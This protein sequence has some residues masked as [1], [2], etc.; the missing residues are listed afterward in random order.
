M[1]PSPQPPAIVGI[2][3]GTNYSMIATMAADGNPVVHEVD[4]HPNR[5]IPSAVCLLPGREGVGEESKRLAAIK[6]PLTYTRFKRTAMASGEEFAGAEGPVTAIDL[7]ARIL[8][9]LLE[10]RALED[11]EIGTAVVTVP[12]EF[13]HAARQATKEAAVQAGLGDVRLVNEPTAAAVYYVW[14]KGGEFTGNLAVFDLGGGTLDVTILRA[15]GWRVEV[16]ATGGLIDLGG[17]DFDDA[18]VDFVRREYETR[19]GGSLEPEDFTVID[20][21]RAKINL[22]K[23]PEERIKVRG[24]VGKLT[25]DITRSQFEELITPVLSRISG[26]IEDVIERSGLTVADIDQLLAVGGSTRI[27]AVRRIAAEH[28]GIE[29]VSFDHVDQVVAKGAVVFA[30]KE[31]EETIRAVLLEDDVEEEIEELEIIE[32]TGKSF[33]TD[34]TDDQG[35]YYHSIIIPVGTEIPCSKTRKYRVRSSE[36]TSLPC[37]VLESSGTDRRFDSARIVEEIELPLRPDRRPEDLVFVTFGY[38]ENQMMTC[39]F[40]DGEDGELVKVD[41]SGH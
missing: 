30:A 4:G 6:T 20:A 17:I 10:T 18:L 14:Q 12:A 9:T 36:A 5:I 1:S 16:L 11:R 38:D 23:Y 15:D 31:A 40:R 28:F 39:E 25:L 24:N 32:R 29:P 41:I 34:A 35:E 21:E 13:D 7:S 26:L 33:G 27:P 19:S 22:S 3:L 37:M 2:D 8:A